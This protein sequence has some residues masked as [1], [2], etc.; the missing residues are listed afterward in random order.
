MQNSG[1][2]ESQAGNKI[3]RRN[4]SNPRYADNTMLM[5]ENEEELKTVNRWGW[6][7]RVEKLAWN[8]TF[9]KLRWHTDV[10]KGEA[11]ADFIFLGSK[12]TMDGD[13]SHEIQQCLLY[14]RK[15]MT[16]LDRVL[17]STDITLPI[18]VRID[19]PTVF[20]VVMYTCKSW[21]IKKIESWKIDA[22]KLW[23]WRKLLRVPWTVRR[24]KQQPKR[25]STL[26]I[27]WKDWGWSWSSHNLATW[28]K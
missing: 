14:G 20:P 15:T 28:Y 16:N 5:T 8:S 6:K 13:C 24:S 11:V 7:R 17:K 19:K 26:N 27:H 1:L 18:K 4:I 22:F 12:I 25:K 10:E 3:S 23:C 21:I 9:K 2:G